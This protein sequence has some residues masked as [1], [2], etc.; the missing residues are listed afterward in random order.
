MSY[1]E[2]SICKLK[3]GSDED[4]SLALIRTSWNAEEITNEKALQRKLMIARPLHSF[5]RRCHRG[6]SHEKFC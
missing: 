4:H 5:W 2:D 1:K 3:E 6:Q